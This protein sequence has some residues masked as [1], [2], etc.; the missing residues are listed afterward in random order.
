MRFWDTSA[1][2]PMLIAESTTEVTIDAL[3]ADPEVVA[4]WATRV[5][6]ASALARLERS[7][8]AIDEALERL[9]MLSA[10]WHEIEA[11]ERVRQGAC[12]Y[13]ASTLYGP[14]MRCS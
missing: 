4:W 13:Y 3:G 2:L 12:A 6:C 9:E 7:G 5:E 8:V 10:A 14:P 11:T 1:L